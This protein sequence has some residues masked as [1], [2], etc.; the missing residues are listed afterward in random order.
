MEIFRYI[1]SNIAS[2][3]KALKQVKSM[4]DQS[5]KD[6]NLPFPEVPQD[7]Y[8]NV[9]NILQDWICWITP[10]RKIVHIL[11][12]S[13]TPCGYTIEDFN[14]NPELMNQV[15][16][17]EESAHF[18]KHIEVEFTSPEILRTEFRVKNR[19]GDIRW[20]EHE[21]APYYDQEGNFLGRITRNRDVTLYHHLIDTLRETNQKLLEKQKIF[22]SGPTVVFKWE[23]SPELPVVY[24]SENVQEVLGYHPEEFLKQKITFSHI[25]HPDDLKTFQ[26]EISLPVEKN[27]EHFYI[28][29]FRVYTASGSIVWLLNNVTALRNEKGEITH[30]LGY[31]VDITPQKLREE[32]LQLH[33]QRLQRLQQTLEKLNRAT[34][35]EEIYRIAMEGIINILGADRASILLFTEDGKMHFKGWVNLSEE[36]R[37]QVDGH[38]PWG[39]NEIDATPIWISHIRKSGFEAEIRQAIEKEG[40]VSL[41]FVPLKS[42]IRLLGKFMIYYNS[43]HTFTTEE[44]NFAQILAE[45]LAAAISRANAHLQ[46]QKSESKYRS[47]FQN[48]HEGIYIRNKEGKL[49]T[50][51]PAL[52]RMFGF[53]SPEEMLSTDSP[54]ALFAFSE[55]HQR[56]RNYLQEHHSLVNQEVQMRRKDNTIIWVLL[57][58][59]RLENSDNEE[60]LYQGTIVDI[61]QLKKAEEA[62]KQSEER[63]RALINSTPD[64]IC[65]KDGEGRWQIANEADLKLFQLEGVDYQGKTDSE[66]ARYSPFYYNAFITC[67]QTDEI[68]WQRGTL[69]RGTEIIPIPDG[70]SKIYDVIKVPL[71]NSDGSRRGLVVFGRDITERVV[72]EKALRDNEE[73]F[74]T[75]FDFSPDAIF[76]HH[77]TISGQ[78]KFLEVNR[79]ACERYGYERDEFL[80][81]TPSDISVS[82]PGHEQFMENIR[83]TLLKKRKIVFEWMHRTR[84]GKQFPVEISSTLFNFNGEEAVLSIVRD[85]SERKQAEEAL[86]QSEERFRSVF[87]YTGTATLIIRKDGT[88][89]QANM[90][91]QPL[92]GRTPQEMIG[93]HWTDYVSTEDIPICQQY[94]EQ[95]FKHPGQ[96]QKHFEI[97]IRHKNGT[98]RNCLVS[99]GN[100]THMNQLVVSF[101]DI[102]D[103]VKAEQERRILAKAVESSAEAICIF[104]RNNT[105]IYTNRVFE[106]L[107]GYSQMEILGKNA[108]HIFRECASSTQNLPVGLRKEILQT[109]QSGHTWRGYLFMMKKDQSLVEVQL[110][111]T[112][113]TDQDGKITHYLSMH[114]DMTRER[115][116]ER[117]S[118][119]S[120]RLEAIGT[121]AGGIAHDFNNILTPILGYTDLALFNV[122]EN[123]KL[124]AHLQQI[125]I[126]AER[127]RSLVEQILSFSRRTSNERKPILISPIVKEA[128]K[129]LRAS[130]PTTIEIRSHIENSDLS[131]LA[132]PTEIHQ[133][134]I[135]LCTNAYQAMPNGG[136]LEV[137]L[138][139][140]DVVS[141]SQEHPPEL[142]EGTYLVLTIR[143]T[144][145]G[146]P[147]N[148]IDKIFEP[149]FTTRT[150]S[151]GTGLGLAIVHGIV[152]SYGGTITVQSKPGQGTTF[153]IYLP[154]VQIQPEEQ[155]TESQIIRGK[156]ER[157]LLLDDEYAITELG[158]SILKEF[159]YQV[160]SFTQPRSALEFLNQH[161][162]SVDLIITDLTMPGMTGDKFI[163]KVRQIRPDIPVI[164]CTGYNTTM[165]PQKIQKL[166]NAKFIRKPFSPLQLSQAVR[167]LLDAN[168]EKHSDE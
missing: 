6:S 153:R 29:P 17:P 154:T 3:Q 14:Q 66:L 49:L 125:R 148:I 54:K 114:R 129:L 113:I 67:E 165:N 30:F 13:E 55:D 65:F 98:G 37:R 145:I 21:C 86:R 90:E 103:R 62:L 152:S 112:P 18:R 155:K 101:W 23:N 70:S 27:Q 24:V 33:Y 77:P 135:N 87:E 167:K 39:Q 63:L 16:H 75:L 97:V 10:D 120:Q 45:N 151:G 166:G 85:I 89:A 160:T 106:K 136:T 94:A 51:N 1:I 19:N 46:L 138:N 99:L 132:D 107:Y 159:G 118:Q 91:C 83:R 88:I 60:E 93:T 7:F 127:A 121:L 102:T 76:V 79:V 56:L 146:I 38:S 11:P 108:E 139:T 40:I 133:I 122:P 123:S 130:I 36:Y 80:R 115:E 96:K 157:I 26:K 119:Q 74:R 150:E 147:P 140:V 81:L 168:E 162:N 2:F 68:A 124:H 163:D 53:D 92:F 59:H 34:T 32:E 161:P 126:A 73:R 144:G 164:L 134:V 25:I 69:S 137:R 35:L 50:V 116:M 12:E 8:K 156:Q 9:F 41:G 20:I 48:T 109:V 82:L 61:T 64:I 128:L 5:S 141:D 44:K 47:I 4:S 117:R 111:V 15:I 149:Y 142:S 72:T 57:N 31:V 131:V 110:T 100:I 104:D 78:Q 71:Y 43:E 58:E 105:V 95:G 84:D 158:A 52:A 143:D 28:P 42:Q 22:Q